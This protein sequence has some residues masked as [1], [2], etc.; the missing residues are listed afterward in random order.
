[1]KCKKCEGKC[2]CCKKAIEEE[3]AMD[4]EDAI[5]Y[6]KR[7]GVVQGEEKFSKSEKAEIN[8]VMKHGKIYGD[9]CVQLF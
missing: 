2:D 9:P 7:K 6:C 5:E 8:K 1:M 4:E 3:E